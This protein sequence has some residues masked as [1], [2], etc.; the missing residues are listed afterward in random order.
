MK[1]PSKSDETSFQ[2]SKVC[3]FGGARFVQADSLH[4]TIGLKEKDSF[5]VRRGSLS[6]LYANNFIVEGDELIFSCHIAFSRAES[7]R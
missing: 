3:F 5:Q 7:V 6:K 4:F 1:L 2:E